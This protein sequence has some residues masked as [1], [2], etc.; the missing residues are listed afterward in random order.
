MCHL[1][2]FCLSVVLLINSVLVAQ[3]VVQ[4]PTSVRPGNTY[5]I[6]YTLTADK[7]GTYLMQESIPL[8]LK[9]LT[10]QTSG[11]YAGHYGNEAYWDMTNMS[12][13]QTATCTI[14]VQVP[15]S[16]FVC[17]NTPI[18]THARLYG[19]QG[20]IP[21]KQSITQVVVELPPLT[22]FGIR[23][24]PGHQVTLRGPNGNYA[25]QWYKDGQPL[26][27]ATQVT[28]T[29]AG[30]VSETGVYSLFL[31]D[32]ITG[33]GN[34]SQALQLTIAAVFDIG[35]SDMLTYQW[36]KDGILLKQTGRELRLN[37]TESETGIYS[38]KTGTVSNN[39]SKIQDLKI[40]MY[41]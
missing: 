1:K 32:T 3:L 33:C 27:D 29:L 17:G 2:V 24:A 38:V 4:A 35:D 9:V 31:K 16:G 18:S 39:C 30:L 6:T 22:P 15:A 13:G 26:I 10:I 5:T 36:L 28:F 37:G 40:T 11:G 41:P 25:Y 19:P 21:V 7:A 23:S 8:S 12:V 34:F 14:Q 20:Y